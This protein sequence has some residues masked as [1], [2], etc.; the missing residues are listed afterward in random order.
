MIRKRLETDLQESEYVDEIEPNSLIT[1]PVNPRAFPRNPFRQCECHQQRWSRSKASIFMAAAACP[2]HPPSSPLPESFGK[3]QKQR[4]LEFLGGSLEILS[5]E[6]IDFSGGCSDLFDRSLGRSV[7]LP[8]PSQQ[9]LPCLSLNGFKSRKRFESLR[10]R[11][12]FAHLANM[13]LG[14]LACC[15]LSRIRKG[16]GSATAD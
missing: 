1:Q 15:R 14:Q 8:R 6:L 9:L 4:F 16:R 13:F 2:S 3:S 5:I 12:T 10:M 11:Q 7:S